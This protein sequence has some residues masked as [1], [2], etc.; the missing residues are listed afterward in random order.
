MFEFTFELMILAASNSLFMFCFCNLI[1]VSLLVGS[2]LAPLFEQDA[3]VPHSSMLGM[4]HKNKEAATPEDDFIH[5]NSDVKNVLTDAAGG[6][7]YTETQ[8]DDYGYGEGDHDDVGD[9]NDDEDDDENNA[10]GS[11]Y[12]EMQIDDNGYGEGDHD[13]VGDGND[14]EDDDENNGEEE[15][16]LRRRVEEFIAKVNRAWKAE[17]LA[18][19]LIQRQNF[20]LGTGMQPI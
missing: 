5:V 9:G 18:S 8:I 17:M 12:T 20:Q 19:H 2:K 3:A 7:D 11:D 14:D 16:E 15:D 10:G 4:G 13:D 1:I 6:S